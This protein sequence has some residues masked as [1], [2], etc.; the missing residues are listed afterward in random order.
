MSA[1]H[2]RVSNSAWN[3]AGLAIPL[4]LAALS[5]P[6]TIRYLGVE[7]FGLLALAWTGIGYVSL[8]D[9]GLGRVLTKFLSERVAANTLGT[10]LNSAALLLRVSLVLGLAG[11]GL[12]LL[13]TPYVV[14]SL[15]AVA[16]A[17]SSEAVAATYLVA[18]AV[19]FV[20]SS[21]GLRGILEGLG[22]FRWVCYVRLVIGVF[23]FL[24]PLIVL[25]FWPTLPAVI[26]ALVCGRV[27]V[28][29][30]LLRL[31]G[32]ALPD[33]PSIWRRTVARTSPSQPS[34]SET[35]A[36]ALRLGGWMTVSN[37]VSPLMV[38]MDRFVIGALMPATAIAYYVTPFEVATK[39][40][41]LPGAVS[42][43]MFPS[44]SADLARGSKD[45]RRSLLRSSC[46]TAL[47]LIPT[48]ILLAGFAESLLRIWL[49][50]AFA[51]QSY[52]VLQILAVG[53]VLN[54]VAH[55]PFAFVQAAGRADLTA[56]LHMA[57]LP[58]YL[59]TLTYLAQHFGIEGVAAAWVLRVAVDLVALLLLTDRP[60]RGQTDLHALECV[61]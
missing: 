25:P 3:L 29:V 59:L 27:A 14:K 2:T 42:G 7:R 48:A 34:H 38:S 37:V 47:L 32:R 16:P 18:L 35:L 50:P 30:L 9:A 26:A 52:R 43:V 51:A 55:L 41:I 58:V 19:P 60:L 13:A 6:V 28:W 39:L 24:L 8:F 12:L 56:K 40:L 57:E 17:L 53:V 36:E 22:E 33:L 21:A 31:C 61:Q 20:A 11:S 46:A 45:A 5:I 4:V 1:R 44:F 10:A 49:G 23:T 15:L 54:G